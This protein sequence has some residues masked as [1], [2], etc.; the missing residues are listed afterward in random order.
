M[1]AAMRYS[2]GGVRIPRRTS[3]NKRKTYKQPNH[4]S[5]SFHA[6][7]GLQIEDDR[8]QDT[9]LVGP[10]TKLLVCVVLARVTSSFTLFPLTHTWRMKRGKLGQSLTVTSST[11]AATS[12]PSPWYADH[13]FCVRTVIVFTLF[14]LADLHQTIRQS[15]H[16]QTIHSLTPRA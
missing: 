10:N 16:V 13:L 15:L 1:S 9:L 14:P 11:R 3:P 4:Y 2:H 7:C 5:S 12:V 6:R 8:M